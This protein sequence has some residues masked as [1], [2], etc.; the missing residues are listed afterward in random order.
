LKF[1]EEGEIHIKVRVKDEFLEIE[2]QDTGVGISL[3]NQSK[4]FKMFGFLEET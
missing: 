4:L 1:T 2:V 3:D